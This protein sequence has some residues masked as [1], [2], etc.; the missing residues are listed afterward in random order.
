[1]SKQPRSVIGEHPDNI[2]EILVPLHNALETALQR[3]VI[4]GRRRE[5]LYYQLFDALRTGKAIEL[6]IWGEAQGMAISADSVEVLVRRVVEQAIV[7]AYVAKSSE[8]ASMVDR[9]LKTTGAEWKRSF[10]QDVPEAAIPGKCLPTY[11]QMAR[12]VGGWLLTDY[13]HLSYV[14]H[15]RGAVPYRLIERQAGISSHDFFI[16]RVGG[17]LGKLKSAV[18]HLVAAY[19]EVDAA[20]P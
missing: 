18:Q 7:A 19:E 20:D 17:A 1:M 4:Q 14:S 11:G 16:L 5:F 8:S 15:P 13:K 3:P 12:E 9:Y 2:G 10:D 6:L